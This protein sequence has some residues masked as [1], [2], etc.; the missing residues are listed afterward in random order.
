MIGYEDEENFNIIIII[1]HTTESRISGTR[2]TDNDNQTKPY[3]FY[4]IFNLNME[5]N[6]KW[7]LVVLGN[8]KQREWFKDIFLFF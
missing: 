8:W 7:N 3:T 2:K 5:K 6:L 4:F 1:K